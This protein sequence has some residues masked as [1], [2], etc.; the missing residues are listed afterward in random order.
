MNL[1]VSTFLYSNTTFLENCPFF[2]NS[3]T[4]IFLIRTKTIFY[5]MVGQ[6]VNIANPVVMGSN[7]VDTAALD[8]GQVS[9]A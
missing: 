9:D 3:Y 1:E 4:W 6:R 2:R 5:T 7:E 8:R